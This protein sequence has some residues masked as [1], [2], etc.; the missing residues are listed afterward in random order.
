MTAAAPTVDASA[1]APAKTG[2]KKIVLIVAVVVAMLCGVSAATVFVLKKKATAAL[3]GDDAG[4]PDA[5][6]V[7]K[8][9]AKHPPTFLPLDPFVVNLADKDADRYAQIGI[10]LELADHK[11]ADEMVVNMPAI[12]NGILMIL[13][14]KDSHELL[15]RSGKERLAREIQREAARTMGL[16]VDTAAEDLDADA[17]GS[18][19]SGATHATQA[20]V[21]AAS[22]VRTKA[23]AAAKDAK[24]A[25]EAASDDDEAVPKAGAKS[26]P[27]KPHVENP[28]RHVHFSNFIIQ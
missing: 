27:G 3:A 21:A 7:V 6:A 8:F 20:L 2:K 13:A 10:T 23:A 5:H 1:G 17:P 11:F 26:A 25:T 9:D 18:A 16:D 22:A 19:S 24:D 15:E 28:I 4:A 14:H 12:R